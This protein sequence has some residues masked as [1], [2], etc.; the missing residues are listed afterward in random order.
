MTVSQPVIC[1]MELGTAIAFSGSRDLLSSV[2]EPNGV[3]K[4]AVAQ[5]KPVT[6]S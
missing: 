5:I 3:R 2:P 1:S 4:A 6:P